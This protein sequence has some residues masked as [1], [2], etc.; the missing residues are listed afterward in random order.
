MAMRID[1]THRAVVPMTVPGD[2][3]AKWTIQKNNSITI[4]EQKNAIQNFYTL[5]L[6][7]FRHMRHSGGVG[8]AGTRSKGQEG[9]YSISHTPLL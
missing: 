5:L 8:V 2:H 9:R 4:G 7:E 3:N 1:C 6:T